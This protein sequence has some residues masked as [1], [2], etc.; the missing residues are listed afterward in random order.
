MH[1]TSATRSYCVSSQSVASLRG[2]GY[3]IG[4][5]LCPKDLQ[6]TCPDWSSIWK[7]CLIHPAGDR[8]PLL[9]PLQQSIANMIL[10]Q[11]T[12]L[13]HNSGFCDFG[14]GDTSHLVDRSMWSHRILIAT[15]TTFLPLCL[16][17][18]SFFLFLPPSFLSFFPLLF[19][20][21]FSSPSLSSSPSLLPSVS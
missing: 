7:L 6:R 4:A 20:F 13:S 1:E 18:S 10:S 15:R 19:P 9:G 11:T 12:S 17:L 5:K 16:L 14:D 21:L 3:T 8:E 2:E